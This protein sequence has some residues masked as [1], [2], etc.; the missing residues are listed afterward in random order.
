VIQPPEPPTTEPVE[1]LWQKQ[2]DRAR[3]TLQENIKNVG[4]AAT[5]LRREADALEKTVQE[6]ITRDVNMQ[7]DLV[8]FPIRETTIDAFDGDAREKYLDAL[9]AKIEERQEQLSEEVREVLIAGTQDSNRLGDLDSVLKS[10]LADIELIIESETGADVDLASGSRQVSPAIAEQTERYVER[11]EQ[12]QDRGGLSLY[13]DSDRDGISDFDENTIY[14]TDPYSAHT[15]G[16]EL[17]DGERVLLGLDVT[18][19]TSEFVPVESP[20]ETG[21]VVDGLFEVATISRPPPEPSPNELF[22]E[23]PPQ[24]YVTF[25]GA[26]LPNSFVTLYIFST[27]IV[28]TVKTDSQGRWKY[29]MDVELEDGS[30]E[31][32]VAM[33]DNAGRIL[34]KSPAVPFVQ[35]AEAIEFAPLLAPVTPD[36]SPIDVIRE[37][38]VA[39]SILAFFCVA[40]IGL[41]VA[42]ILRHR[43]DIPSVKT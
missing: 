10:S 26:G 34:A 31:L 40:L 29:T 20:R 15:A 18:S 24:Q 4:E 27:P 1:Q 3:A 6:S 13:M 17:T 2:E 5:R 14:K 39:L 42:G 11:V 25:E 30:H 37:Y 9:R 32:H 19:V 8:Q 16:S 36:P 28:V 38:F 33:V 35:T 12:L 22:N 41:A 23:P 7:L 21:E 43:E